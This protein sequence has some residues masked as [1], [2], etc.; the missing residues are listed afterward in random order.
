MMRKITE[1]RKIRVAL[2][3]CGR[4]SASH[5]E[6]L[7]QMPEEAELV[8][9][10]DCVAER[11][12]EAGKKYNTEV[13]TDYDQML[14]QTECDLVSIAT[15]SGLHPEM[16]VKAAKAGRHVMTEKPM[17]ISLEGADSLISWCDKAGVK[18]FVVKQNR[19]N[20]TMQLLKNAIDKGRFG[21]IYAAHVNVFWQRPQEYYDMA[22][23]RGTWA[24]DGGA[25]MNQASHY[26]DSIQW[27]VGDVSE[28]MAITETLAR[29]TEAEDTGSAV[30]KFACGAI[31]SINVTMLT[32]PKNLEGSVTILGEKGTVKVGGV[33]INKIENWEFSSY[34]DD[35]KL[36]EQSNYSPPNVYG[37]GHLPYYKNVFAI[38]KG[39]KAPGTDGREGRKSL[40][41]I[42]AIYRSSKKRIPVKLPLKK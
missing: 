15:P 10:C 32:Y 5:L 39:Q 13:F 19:L 34:D 7:A 14:K 41:I 33:A 35:D 4:I 26:V 17:A 40:E 16:G 1:D 8:A 3:G 42:L 29:K 18:L 24:L 31:G 37:F 36:I 38:L 22:P 21:K 20:T 30:L 23:W 25:F 28:V 2:V 9:V 27:L 12:Q 11:A 6:S